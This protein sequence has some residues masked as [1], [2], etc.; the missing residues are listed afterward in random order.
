MLAGWKSCERSLVFQVVETRIK[1]TNH[2]KI[3]A[4]NTPKTEHMTISGLAESGI[5]NGPCMEYSIFLWFATLGGV[6]VL[7]FCCYI[8]QKANDL[9]QI[10]HKPTQIW[11]YDML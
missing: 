11:L 2:G 3:F 7:Y 8:A 6:R 10:F 5:N 1:C 4:I 9:L